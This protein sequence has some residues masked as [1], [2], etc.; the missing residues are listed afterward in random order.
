MSYWSLCDEQ[1]RGALLGLTL[2]LVLRLC[3]S[4]FNGWTFFL[5]CFCPS[6]FT[7]VEH[8]V[9]SR[10]RHTQTVKL[11]CLGLY[12]LGKAVKVV[13]RLWSSF[14]Q[15]KKIVVCW[16]LWTETDEIV[17]LS[18]KSFDLLIQF[19][20]F[21]KK[22]KKWQGRSDSVRGQLTVPLAT[23]NMTNAGCSSFFRKWNFI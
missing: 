19:V 22:R 18:V 13:G 6:S 17:F 14:T 15:P 20:F 4:P 10:R 1:I 9:G 8:G 16:L 21:Y 7:N 11:F 23:R 5:T 12:C 3:A 2:F